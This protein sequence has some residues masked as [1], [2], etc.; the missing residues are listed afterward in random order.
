MTIA[1]VQ[2]QFWGGNVLESWNTSAGTN[3]TFSNANKSATQ[4]SG[5][6]T[7]EAYGLSSMPTTGKWYFEV[8]MDKSSN[9]SP[10][11]IGFAIASPLTGS[12]LVAMARGNAALSFVAAGVTSATQV[13][14][15]GVSSRIMIAFDYANRKVWMGEDGTWWSSGNPAA[16]TNP[17]YS[18]LPGGAW[19]VAAF[20]DNNGAVCQAHLSFASGR[21][22]YS[23]PAGFS[24]LLAS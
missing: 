24:P 11:A 3:V 20:G 16:N 1:F 17:Y 18:N 12:N 6:S 23:A 8:Q 9:P 13:T 21:Q 7:M 5:L 15:G 10:D 2:P 4:V 19:K 14:Y 22:L